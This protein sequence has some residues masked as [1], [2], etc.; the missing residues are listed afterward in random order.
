[1]AN[2]LLALMLLF[3]A[4]FT[5]RADD[6]S[7]LPN[8]TL[9]GFVPGTVGPSNINIDS[10]C[11]IR[12]FPGG[13]T[14]NFSFFTQPGQTDQRWVVIFDNVNWTGNMSCDAVHEHKIW[15]VNGS[16]STLQP[17]CQNYLIP[18]EKIDKS[19]PSGQ[20]TATVGV[21][22]T[23]RLKIPVLFDPA[24]DGTGV[25]ID[26]QGSPNDLHG[27]TVTDDLNA[28]G[29]VLSYVSHTAT[30]KSSG[31]PVPHT[32][33]NANGSLTF[34]FA[35]LILPAGEQIFVDITVVL[36]DV[37][38]NAIGTVFVN[39]AK[40]DF[41]RLINGDFF[42]PLPG[43]NGI[44]PPLTIAAPNLIVNKSGPATMNLG[45]TG[46]FTIDVLN[47]GL[48]DAWDVTLRDRLPDG[49]NGGM[50]DTTPVISSVTLAGTAL[51]QGTHYT[52][53]YTTGAPNCQLTL[54]LTDA[55]G[56]IGPNEHL[57][58]TYQTE[59]DANT[60]N[61][62]SLT[63]VA[64]ATEW[65]NGDST[66]PDRLPY[67]RQ[68]TNGT[69]GVDDHQDAHTVTVAIT[70]FFF[71]KTVAN[72]TTGAN[73][74]T[75]AAP[76]HTLRY[77]LRLQSADEVFTN[78]R[79]H[80]ELD[81]L[82]A[83][84]AF[85]PGSLTLVSYPAGADISNTSSTGGAKGTGVIDI[86]NLN[87]AQGGV[88]QIQFD[89]TLAGSVPI[90][91]VVTN[92][93][94]LRLAN[95]T[96]RA[97]SDDP[98][99]N[100]PA[101]P[102]VAGDEDPTRVTIVPTALV[103]EKTVAN[104]TTGV[105][106]T[107]EARPGDRL[108]YRLRIVNQASFALNNVSL[109][110]EL[111]HLNAVA[112]FQPGTLTVISVPAGA[113]AT[114]TTATGG[115]KGTG[116]LDV[117][118]LALAAS[119]G[120][121]ILEFEVTLAPVIANG[122]Y[123]LNQSQL[124][125]A[126]TTIAQSDDPNVNGAADPTIAG[127]E[128]PTRVRIVS[129]PAFQV[130]KTSTDLSGDP[131]VLLAGETLRYTITVKNV[132]NADATDALL[133]DQIPVN[134]T[135]VAGSTRLNGA[136]VPDSGGLS[137][138]VAGMP[139]NAPGSPSGTI[140]ADA[141][142]SQANV[143][144]ITFNVV[145][146]P[147]VIDGTVISNQGYVSAPDGGVSDI[148][149]DD[150][151]TP[152]ANDPT[153]DVVGNLPL[154]YAEKRVML[155]GDQGTPGAV[156]PGDV[157]RYTITVQNSAAIA[158]T[159]VVL[160]DA[161]PAN[162]TY[163]AD[164]TS[165]NGLPVGQ[166]DGGVS[167][168]SVGIDV[169]SS[170]LTPPL[171]GAGAG[172]ISA[173][174][175]AVMQYDLRVNDGVPSGTLI[176]N[177]A[178]VYSDQLPN[179]LTDGDGN[180]ATGPE[181]TV[182]VVGDGQQLAI[183]KTVA[184]VGGGPALSG[185][186]LEY[187]VTVTNIA[188][189]PAL[190]VVITDDLNAQQNNYLTYVDQS[191]TM[192]GSTA[193]VTFAG[194]TITADYSAG[195]GQLA[196]GAT[197]VLRFRATIAPNLAMGTRIT[198]TGVV[199]WNNPPQTASASV[200]IDIGGTPGAGMLNGTAWHDADFDDTHDTTERYLEGWSV[201]LYRDGELVA[202]TQTDA[203]GAYHLTGVAPNYATGQVYELRFRAP[204]A[205]GTTAAL[206]RAASVFTN[207]PQRIADIIV[208]PGANL[209]DLN[210]PIDPDGVIYNSVTRAPIAGAIVTLLDAGSGAELPPVCF[211]DPVQQNQVTLAGGF[212]KFDINFS[213]PACPS[214]GD[215]LIGVKAPGTGYVAGYSQMIPPIAGPTTAPFSVPTCA[216]GMSD[217]I[218]GTG[219]YC[220]A[221][222]SELAPG[223]AVPARSAGTNHYVH[224]T[225]DGTQPPGSS[226][227]F[228]NHIP[229]DPTLDGAIAISKTTP[230]LN[231][232]RGQLVPYTITVTNQLGASLQD[233]VIVDRYP[234][235][236]TYVEGSARMD[237]VPVEPIVA[238]REL[239]WSNLTVTGTGQHKL[240]LLLAVG[241][242][243]TEGE[244]V[245]RAQA[246]NGLTGNAMS[247]EASATVRIIPD[248]TFDCTDVT[249][250][251]FDD[252]NRNKL[253]DPGEKGLAGVRVVTTR[254][255]AAT[256]DAFGRFHI[257]CAITPV[258]GRGSNFV[259]KLDDR[260]LPSGYRPSTDEVL[261]QR[262]T[263]GKALKFDFGASIH[264]VVSLDVADAV[265]EP[266]T[267]EM[268]RQWKPRLGLLL[269]ELQ[270]APATLRLSYLAD[271]EDADLVNRRIEALRKQISESWEA[272]DCCYQLT[273][274]PEVFWRLGAPPE[275]SALRGP[276]GR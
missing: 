96:V 192:N 224:L 178:V 218:P 180:P 265:F 29:A 1:M 33:T 62:A 141:S 238:G 13:L 234:A 100:G 105:D 91:T 205:T 6:C 167:P 196:P 140:P 130:Q 171:P 75:T 129:A 163:V 14:T 36:E 151:D 5:A 3:G 8:H 87:V 136:V 181:P 193:G 207:Y 147:T 231:V 223:S 143:A 161:V 258:E 146:D 35:P 59:L 245:N 138:L 255:L 32:F 204:G 106:P 37:P 182:V 48:S 187:V 159:A 169:S 243:V 57:V 56:A 165:L 63:N 50:C 12:N 101:D 184:V 230:M 44:S 232:T 19:I 94:Q 208:Q 123:V 253:Q 210:L 149:S 18:V 242:G 191:A 25:V 46:Q 264:R 24:G 83:Q 30:F 125:M 65:F 183:T 117:R 89:V 54:T 104:V 249:G 145:V 135:Y 259:L 4:A 45:E 144:T 11:T 215:Y 247:G 257:T 239:R 201:E 86:R 269:R 108:R 262:A 17:N 99:V 58:V 102:D 266:G 31:A 175:S 209:Q 116:V 226:Q 194:T 206:G 133:R 197:V 260:T 78:V 273:I 110:D 127:D 203:T 153:R 121:A 174:A 212:Y 16:L 124:V 256:T 189:T 113:N 85:A 111:D 166:P 254:G 60:Q 214:G 158:A 179:L 28:T 80:D 55:A 272:L 49:P 188:A 82:N 68:L 97:L 26:D 70:G 22:F 27:I 43:E 53:S 235:G 240:L 172:T 134:T 216:G 90:G 267:T 150:P 2:W 98:N 71:E 95:N 61:G 66:I 225:L 213:N 23:Y 148:P 76:G 275:Q 15:L 164:S 244:Y 228:N 119:G 252:A 38:A 10:N 274:E 109:R 199:K 222:T 185:K 142:N 118:G 73:P 227:L 157:L 72:L 271:V 270:K 9:D 79:I 120:T 217:A 155:I 173:H 276:S 156:D 261:V 219:Q 88:I 160:R 198:N 51:T 131:A 237:D 114:N 107:A 92:Q 69:V 40:W 132:G 233:V 84:A 47:A 81:A 162:T 41:G 39:T 77:T 177:Q 246:V 139:I 122:T 170:D 220:E 202:T 74:T 137:P 186:Q 21:P 93:S 263:R 20:T 195:T 34:E 248:A 126:G 7:T 200:S 67:T 115:A 52:L 250:K 64:G 236:F 128:D 168:L 251:V 112:E 42:E 229:L 154:L 103:F 241:A 221:Q 176:S 268:R 211:D 152:I 190:Y